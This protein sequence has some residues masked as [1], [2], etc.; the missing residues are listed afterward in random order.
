MFLGHSIDGWRIENG[1]KGVEGAEGGAESMKKMNGKLKVREIGGVTKSRGL[2]S[3]SQNLFW[4][5]IRDAKTLRLVA[6]GQSKV[7]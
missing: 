3:L 5:F 6:S 4:V 1:G 7:S 2:V